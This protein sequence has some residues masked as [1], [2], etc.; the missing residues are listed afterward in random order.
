MAKQVVTLPA[1]MVTFV[2]PEWREKY[3]TAANVPIAGTVREHATGVVHAILGDY[4]ECDLD[5]RSSFEWDGRLR[6][7]A[8]WIIVDAPI[9]CVRCIYEAQWPGNL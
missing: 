7:G 9:T 6:R 8:R 2:S 3:E 4:T 5:W 1:W